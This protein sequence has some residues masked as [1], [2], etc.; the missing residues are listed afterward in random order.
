MDKF[1]RSIIGFG[2]HADDVDGVVLCRLFNTAIITWGV[3][4][5]LSSDNDPLFLYHRWQANLRIL[6][7]DEI[8]TV[9]YMPRS[10]PFVEQLIGS[11][12]REYLDHI[13]FWNPQDLERK[14]DTFMHYYNQRRVHQSLDGDAPDEVSGGHPSPHA[15]L[16]NYLWAS[17]NNGLFKTPIAA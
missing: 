3:P 1:T 9:P 6:S 17:H 14:L 5:Y 16:G 15:K 13:F 7:V 2:V 11:I 4:K 8:K 10:H 12:R